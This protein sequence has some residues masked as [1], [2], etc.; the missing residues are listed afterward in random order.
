M[1]VR[2]KSGRRKRKRTMERGKRREKT[3][4]ISVSG[5]IM[6]S[7]CLVKSHEITSVTAGM[8]SA[9]QRQRGRERQRGW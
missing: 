8:Y 6:E 5:A 1:N 4:F 9:A 7:L 2:G 3:E